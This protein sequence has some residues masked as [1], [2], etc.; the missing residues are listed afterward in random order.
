MRIDWS[1]MIGSRQKKGNPRNDDFY[2]PKWLFESL[3]VRFDLDVCAPTGGV[4]WLP[5]DK[6]FDI[7]IDGLKQNW[8]GFIW[9]N[10]PYSN[11]KPF[12]E[13][14]ILHANGIMLVQVSKSDAFIKLWNAADAIMLL[15]RD[16]KFEHK[17]NGRK[18]I[19]MPVALF[20]MGKKAVEVI[21]STKINRVR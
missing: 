18:D 20:G 5:A 11:P 13:K 9:C 4:E 19:F 6:H 17:D 8:H 1:K 14:F 15:P 2:T 3:N 16:I 10:P 12:I 21:E 7:E